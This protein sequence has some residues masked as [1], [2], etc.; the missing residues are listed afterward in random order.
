IGGGADGSYNVLFIGLA[1]FVLAIIL[2]LNRIG[3]FMVRNMAVLI[4]LIIGAFVA[5]GLGS[6]DFGVI[7][8]TAWISVPAP[9]YF[10]LPTFSVV[11]IISMIIEL[12]VQM[13]ES[14]GLFVAIGDLAKKDIGVLETHAGIP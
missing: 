9:F 12:T 2:V 8:E 6:Y 7:E 4:A 13:I 14:M 11:P 1:L 5:I 10:G 3:S